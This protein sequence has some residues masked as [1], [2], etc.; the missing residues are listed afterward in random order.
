MTLEELKKAYAEKGAT[1]R[2]EE[3]TEQGTQYY[4]DP[5]QLGGGWTAWENQPQMIGY[6]GQGMDATPIYGEIDPAQKLGGFQ[7]SEG[8][9]NYFYDTAGNLVHV[10]KQTTDWDTLGPIIMA[11]ASG[12][13]GGIPLGETGL[14]AGNV[15]SGAR[16]IENKDLM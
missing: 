9:K 11:A 1:T 3:T 10:E 13:L 8:N 5:V 14:T 2:R 6:E 7:R 15:L 12:Y 4:D 16:A